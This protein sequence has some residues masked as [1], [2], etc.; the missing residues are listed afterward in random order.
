MILDLTSSTDKV[1]V[2]GFMSAQT[3]RKPLTTKGWFDAKQLTGE[4]II[5]SQASSQELIELSTEL[6]CKCLLSTLYHFQCMMPVFLQTLFLI[7]I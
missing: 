2:W 6:D 4:A 5:S 3:T 7:P 1:P